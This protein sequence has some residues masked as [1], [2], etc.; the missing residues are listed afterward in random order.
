MTKF[1]LIAMQSEP[2]SR[3]AMSIQKH[4][5][6]TYNKT[7]CHNKV[8]SWMSQI[9]S[10]STIPHV[11]YEFLPH[12]CTQ[13]SGE[14]PLHTPA[15]NQWQIKIVYRRLT[16]IQGVIH[17]YKMVYTKQQYSIY[18]C[19]NCNRVKIVRPSKKENMHEYY[20]THLLQPLKIYQSHI[21]AFCGIHIST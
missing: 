9:K 12:P 15:T 20:K 6:A 17:L 21:P 11:T 18:H 7:T 16:C 1:S 10:A 5:K 4:H 13:D 14:H 8:I 3:K 2:H 19:G